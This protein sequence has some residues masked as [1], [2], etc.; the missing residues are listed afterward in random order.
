MDHVDLKLWK[1]NESIFH[2]FWESIEFRFVLRNVI[3]TK[4]LATPGDNVTLENS[5]F[6]QGFFGESC[7]F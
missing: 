5:I 2:H 6:S 1:S 3:Y 7:N 4:S